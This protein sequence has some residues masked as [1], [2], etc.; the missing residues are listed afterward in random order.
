VTESD[1]VWFNVLDNGYYSSQAITYHSTFKGYPR[2]SMKVFMSLESEVYYPYMVQAY[3]VFDY[4][5]DYRIWGNVQ[6]ESHHIPAVYLTNQE[7]ADTR[8]DFRKPAKFPKRKDAYMAAFISNCGAR[9]NRQQY[10]EQLMEHMEIHSYGRCHHN[11]D[12]P[13][14]STVSKYQRKLDI[15]GEYFFWFTAENSNAESYVT[16]KIYDALNAGAVPV[17]F[18]ASNVQRFIPHPSAV[19]MADQYSPKELATLLT[20]IAEDPKEYEKY[21]AWKKQP[22]SKDFERILHLASRTVQCRLAMRLEGLE[23]E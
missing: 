10:L 19:I 5:V 22:Y 8:M 4:V 23:I 16:E 13:E 1:A 9:N 2:D 20:N 18:G 21:L 6:K 15:G 3:K 7:Q 14:S 17:Y 11:K 12:E